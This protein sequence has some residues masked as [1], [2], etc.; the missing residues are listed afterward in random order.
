MFRRARPITFLAVSIAVL[1]GAGCG[2][3]PTA[4]NPVNQQVADDVATQMAASIGGNAGSVSLEMKLFGSAVPS[5]PVPSRPGFRAT[6]TTTDTVITVGSVT[7]SI[8]WSFYDADGVALDGWSPAAVRL[9]WNSRATGDISTLRWNAS[10]RR[11]SAFDVN[12]IQAGQDTLV[13][14]GTVRDSIQS[15]FT[16]LDSARTAYLYTLG[17]LTLDHVAALKDTT[18]NPYPLSG[19]LNWSVHVERLRSNQLGDVQASY[20]AEATIEFNGTRYPHI[21][22]ARVYHYIMDL[23][24]GWVVRTPA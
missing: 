4:P 10:L 21:T 14:G 11:T 24:T 8:S 12:G 19:T 7:Y 18:V 17:A 15:Q 23:E 6:A 3:S 5:G 20:D 1:L 9:A 13:V 16:S 2:S 22:V